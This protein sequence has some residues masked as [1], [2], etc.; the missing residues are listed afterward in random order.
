MK[1]ASKM[2]VRAALEDP[3]AFAAIVE[4][5]KAMVF[6]VAYH[7]FQNRGLAEDLAQE[8]FLE[9]YRRL[10]RLESDVH[11]AFWLR[12]AISN[13]CIDYAR[14]SKVNSDVALDAVPE[15]PAEAVSRDPL[16]AG[17]LRRAVQALPKRKRLVVILR[18]QEELELAEIAEVLQ[19]P[20][21]TVKST[22]HRTLSLLKKDLRKEGVP[23]LEAIH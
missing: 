5:Y 13:K 15:L 2:L 18:F 21:N 3:E 6:S 4:R 10:D 11:L 8:V 12:R 23:S 17:R 16:L 1:D 9:L 20:L 7:F 22:L 14:R 19:M